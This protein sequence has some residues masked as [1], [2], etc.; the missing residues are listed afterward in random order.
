MTT[1][2]KRIRIPTKPRFAYVRQRAY[3]LLA[4][5]GIDEFPIDPRTIIR[6][7]PEWH[8][9]GWL[10][11]KCNTGIDDPY[12]LERDGAEAKTQTVR[13]SGEYVIVYD[14]RIESAQR[15]RWTLAHE[16]GHIV[17]GHLT[18]FEGTS[19]ARSGLTTAEY[20]V[21]EV[22]AH[23]FAAELLA[24]QTIV[25]QFDFR[26]NP[27]GIS[28]I[29]DISRDA[30]IKRLEQIRKSTFSYLPTEVRIRRNF[31][32]H[33]INGDFNQVA[34]DTALR[35]YP[36]SI[37]QDLCMGC[38]ICDRCHSFVTDETYR[39][40]PTCGAPVPEPDKYS[41][42]KPHRGLLVADIG[43]IH[44]EIYKQGRQYY[45]FPAID[46][47][48][49]F[50]PVCRRPG[51]ST[52]DTCMCGEPLV[53]RCAV[54]GRVLLTGERF[55]PYCGEP[56]I[57]KALYDQLPER[58]YDGNMAI[59]EELDD[60]IECEYWQFIVMTIGAWEHDTLTYTAL[61]DSYAI[62]DGEDMVIFIR[63]ADAQ[64]TAIRGRATILKCAK[65][66]G[67]LPVK[68]ITVQ[69]AKIRAEV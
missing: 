28:L 51:T 58:L 50:C 55:C 54:E 65:D 20:G 31:Y 40:C 5:L 49:M 9:L 6:C 53:N 17:L 22:E 46:G 24:P 11:L 41:P 59:P 69:V 42:C 7:F 4:D 29:C 66:N 1:P 39:F 35:F 23:Q 26:G 8:L 67:Y 44:K 38:R 61:E 64:A 21:L 14:E 32:N 68:R 30:A 48:L 25:G 33:L 37:Y 16:I 2:E 15:I 18:C 27:K 63:D 36:S 60:Y 43:D 56:A 12:N 52:G 13:G 57:F 45:H 10:E 47:R 62:Y 3:E 34:H 19:L